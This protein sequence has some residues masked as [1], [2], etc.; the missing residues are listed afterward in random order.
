MMNN[1]TPLLYKISKVILGALFKLYYN[2]KIV[3]KE[4]IPTEGPVIVAG[5]HV[6]L[7]DQCLTIL[8]TK[9]CLHYMAKREYFDNKQPLN[10]SAS[11]QTIG[12][13]NGNISLVDNK[14]NIY[15]AK[16]EKIGNKNDKR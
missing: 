13:Q 1:K 5:N 10:E 8:S 6:H 11:L 9:R 3:G 2:P 7:Y 14:G 16:L 12:L 4:N 15:K